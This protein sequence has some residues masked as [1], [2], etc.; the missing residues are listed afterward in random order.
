MLNVEVELTDGTKHIVK[1]EES[2]NSI[3]KELI[4]YDT[5]NLFIKDVDSYYFSAK[6]IIRFKFIEE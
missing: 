3:F 6:S 5:T 2:D 4:R 1:D